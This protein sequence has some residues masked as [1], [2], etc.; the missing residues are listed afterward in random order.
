MKLQTRR[1]GNHSDETDDHREVILRCCCGWF[2]K[3][4]SLARATSLG[5]ST[6]VY[7][8]P[9]VVSVTTAHALPYGVRVHERLAFYPIMAKKDQCPGY[10][11]QKGISESPVCWSL[12]RAPVFVMQRGTPQTKWVLRFLLWR[13]MS[14]AAPLFMP[15]YSEGVCIRPYM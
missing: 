7:A 9:F 8:L 13:Q 14:Q 1:A 6:A 4:R 5:M 2:V 15:T 12:R 11:P 10:P 3:E